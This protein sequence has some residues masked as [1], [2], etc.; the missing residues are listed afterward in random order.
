M[1][2]LLILRKNMIQQI[3]TIVTHG[4]VIWV[5][6]GT[7]ITKRSLL[8]VIIFNQTWRLQT[9]ASLTITHLS[10]LWE[11]QLLEQSNICNQLLAV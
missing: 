7:F 2:R 11:M 4:L 9:A 1:I 5:L 8:S 6:F 3:P 10:K